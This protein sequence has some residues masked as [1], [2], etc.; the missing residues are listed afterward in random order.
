MPNEV[1]RISLLGG[2]RAERRHVSIDR[3][4]THAL[5]CRR[6]D[7]EMMLVKFQQA[8]VPTAMAKVVRFQNRVVIALALR[9]YLERAHRGLLMPCAYLTP[10]G[11]DVAETGIAYLVGPHPDFHSVARE[12][13]DERWDAAIG[14][15]TSAMVFDFAREVGRVADKAPQGTTL[16]GVTLGRNYFLTMELRPVTSISVLDSRVAVLGSDVLITMPDAASLRD[17]AWDFLAREGFLSPTH[18]PLAPVFLHADGSL[19]AI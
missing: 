17:G 10:K 9:G 8:D 3:F 14:A 1:W 11:N 18:L 7:R 12:Q 4:R 6:P 19:H 2:I 13:A 15:G 16:N 5:I